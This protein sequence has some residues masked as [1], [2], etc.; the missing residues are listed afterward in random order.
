VP[1]DSSTGLVQ[2]S[3]CVYLYEV[4][5]SG[6]C[7]GESRVQVR[8]AAVAGDTTPRRVHARSRARGHA[9]ACARD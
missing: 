4:A 5:G 8:G 6:V 9:R 2:V 1:E 3:I 7:A